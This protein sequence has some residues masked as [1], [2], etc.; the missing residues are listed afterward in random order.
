MITAPGYS[1]PD[2]W[3]VQIQAQ[4]QLKAQVLVK[5][6]GLGPGEVRAAHFEP[7]ED[8]T[9]AVRDA[10]ARAGAGRH[11]VRAAAGAADHSLP[12]VGRGPMAAHRRRGHGGIVSIPR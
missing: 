9:G 6:S 12:R 4:I 3:Q 11:A 10:L 1:V 2:Q 5:T 8:V 7:I